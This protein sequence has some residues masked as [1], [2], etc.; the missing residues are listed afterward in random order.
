MFLNPNQDNTVVP[1][2]HHN[3]ESIKGYFKLAEFTDKTDKQKTTKI[4]FF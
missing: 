4:I 1:A 2:K 3:G